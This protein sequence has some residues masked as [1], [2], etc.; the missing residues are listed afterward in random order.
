V[1]GNEAVVGFIAEEGGQLPQG[2]A[3]YVPM[4]DNGR[5]G[6]PAPDLWGPFFL[7]PGTPPMSLN[8]QCTLP[9]GPATVVVTD[10]DVMVHD[11]QLNG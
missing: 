10:G 6:V 2:E 11:G 7:E 1:N 3:I 8:G 5:N 4:V 9:V